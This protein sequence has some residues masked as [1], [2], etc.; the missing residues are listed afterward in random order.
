MKAERDYPLTK[1]KCYS[2]RT[3]STVRRL[4]T[5][6][7]TVVALLEWSESKCSQRGR[8]V[9]YSSAASGEPG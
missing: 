3:N 5:G 2:D 4:D 9:R 1:I 7:Y 8:F 6:A